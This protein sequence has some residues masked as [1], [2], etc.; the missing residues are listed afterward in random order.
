[1]RTA[2]FWVIIMI[3]SLLGG[4]SQGPFPNRK[5]VSYVEGELAK[6]APVQINSDLSGLSDGDVEALKQLLQASH[7]I[8][9]LFLLQVDPENPGLRAELV[10]AG[11][12]KHLELFDIMFGRWNRLVNDEPFLDHHEK[13]LGAGFYPTDMSKKEFETYIQNHPDQEEAFT[14][15]FTLIR[16][17]SSGLKA[18]PY[19]VAFPKVRRIADH[20]KNAANATDDPSLS[21]FLNL[22]AD[23]F[24]TDDYYES[25]MAWMDLS[26]DLEI[27]ISPYEVY[28]DALFNYKAAYEAFLCRVDHEE[29]QKLKNVAQYLNDMERHLPI[30]EKHKNYDRGSSSPIKVVQELYAA[31]DTKAGIQTTAFNLPNDER[32]RKAK[33]SKKVMLKNIARAKFD[34]CWIPIVNTILAEEPLQNVSFEAYF[35]HVL[36]HEMSHGIGPGLITLGNGKETSVAKELKELYSTIEECKADVLGIYN[37]KYMLDMGVFPPDLQNS[38]YASYLG[39]M[40]RSIRFGIDEAHGGGVAIQFNFFMEKG[41]FFV[42]EN[43]KL[44]LN[45]EK[46]YPAIVKLAEKVL[47][48]EATGDYKAARDFIKE[49]RVMTPVMQGY[50]DEL[51][52]VPVDIRPSFDLA[53]ILGMAENK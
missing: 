53:E 24:L 18:V 40:F 1:M 47:M 46:L 52:D 44:D 34:K 50:I 28:E 14:S 39:G 20:L 17:D 41:A 30:P 27:V 36:M 21:R 26:G 31:G 2:K 6:L 11:Y 10:D 43:G 35:N 5:T 23:A 8:D 9:S 3:I 33:G 22:R 16:R 29:S 13:P 42:N 12:Q 32:V 51:Q 38:M 7:L 48:I 45:A 25:D 37:V 49:Y 4:C 19:H 15:E